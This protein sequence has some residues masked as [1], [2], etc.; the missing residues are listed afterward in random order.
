MIEP[1][2]LE[3]KIL[4][5]VHIGDGSE[6]TLFDYVIIDKKIYKIYLN[7]FLASLSGE[8]LQKLKEYQQSNKLI[9]LRHFIKKNV[10]CERF[11]EY[12]STVS[13][14]VK[15]IYDTKFNDIKNQIILNPFIRTNGK[16]FVPGSSIKGAIR[17]ALLNYF[18]NGKG[19][20]LKN[21]KDLEGHILSATTKNSKGELKYSMNKDP[22]RF[23]KV[24]DAMLPE[25]STEF[26]LIT[27]YRLKNDK[28]EETG[29]QIIKEIIIPE[30][31][32]EVEILIDETKHNKINFQ[33]ILEA[34]DKFYKE[35]LKSERER[36]FKD[37]KVIDEFY[38][39]IE[40][41]SYLFRLGFN[42]GFESITL[43]NYRNP[44]NRGHR[45]WGFSKHIIEHKQTFGWIKINII[46]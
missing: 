15:K 30:T 23:I 4:S 35:V 45:G 29:I 32:F 37:Y 12:E 24:R 21:S 40:K 46:S 33:L 42:S 18:D 19:G 31:E 43:K 13:E 27:N 8:E 9:E 41:E 5:P 39:R 3:F 25:N 22:F 14:E 11:K 6:L 16:P 10:D 34:S 26:K 17:T 1:K 7:E 2:K 44:K 36:L 20:F 28:L 38:K